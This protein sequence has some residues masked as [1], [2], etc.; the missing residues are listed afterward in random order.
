MSYS[1]L[2]I[3]DGGTAMTVF[4][5]A[6]LGQYSAAEW[7][8]IRRNLLTYCGQDTLAMVRVHQALAALCQAQMM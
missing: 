6:A 2:E 1:G 3:A 4:A 8:A 5:R 7:A